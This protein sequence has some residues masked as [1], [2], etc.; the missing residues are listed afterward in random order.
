MKKILFSA[1]AV[2]TMISCNKEVANVPD[3]PDDG[4]SGEATYASFTFNSGTKALADFEPNGVPAN[5]AADAVIDVD[6]EDLYI[7]IF[8]SSNALESF[9][10][11]TSNPQTILVSA[12]SQKKIFVLANM[13]NVDAN[14]VATTG[15]P[16]VNV[17]A[18]ATTIAAIEAAFAGSGYS[19]SEFQALAFDAG[20]PQPYDVDK[21]NDSRTFS[22]LPLSTR[23]GGAYNLGLPMSN[24]TKITYTFAANI[25]HGRRRYR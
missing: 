2:M 21:T 13:A 5:D 3:G 7:L 23:V 22:V 9:T 8:N 16:T 4:G 14:L 24:N 6:G 25:R 18:T 12:G 20:T 19:Y 1:L 15:A 17:A 10:K 11:V